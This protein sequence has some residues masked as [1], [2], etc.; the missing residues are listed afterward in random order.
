MVAIMS[1]PRDL[2]PDTAP[3]AP[4]PPGGSCICQLSNANCTYPNCPAG[5]E[6]MALALHAP[7]TRSHSS[8]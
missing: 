3:D 7:L 1:K 8:G 5:G 2:V 4:G 6:P